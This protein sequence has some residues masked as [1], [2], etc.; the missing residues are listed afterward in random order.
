MTKYEPV[1]GLEVHVELMTE[2]KIFCHC[3]NEFGAEPNINT[4]PTCLAMPGTLPVL[5]RQVIEFAIKAGLA[6]HCEIAP[7]AQLERKNYYYPDLPKAYQISQGD[8]PLCLGGY[9]DIETKNGK[10]RVRLNHIHIEEDA[11]K[12]THLEGEGTLVDLNR[13]GVPLIEIV[14]EPDIRS[15]EEADALLRKIRSIVQYTGV[16]DGR[17]DR[18][19][20]RCDVNLSVRPLGSEQLGTRTE[21]NNINSFNFVM[22]TI[23]HEFKRQVEVLE[24]GGEIVQ[25]TRRFDSTSGTTSSMRSKADATDYRYFPDPDLV[26]IVVPVEEVN[27]I[28]AQIP[29]LPDVR[30][31]EYVSRWDLTDYDADLL[32]NDIRVADFFE[33]VAARTEYAKIA[34]NLIIADLLPGLAEEGDVPLQPEQ[35]SGLSELLGREEINSNTGRKVMKAM[36]AT[37]EH[38]DPIAYVDEHKLR[39]INDSQLLAEYV[40]AALQ[41]SAKAVADYKRGKEAALRSIMGQVMR[42]TSGRANPLLTEEMIKEKIAALPDPE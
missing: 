31:Q 7:Y 8:N 26:P 23:E 10:K 13:A 34:A 20:L 22:K 1:I 12:L 39:Q 18:G 15:A 25:E 28:K 11:G 21:M 41:T 35:L 5:N 37:D 4:C 33:E 16:S 3:K 24:A 36:V 6:C 40:D 19:S 9:L 29:R 30:I 17:M 38:I 42:K 2:R 27:R 32:T 14:T